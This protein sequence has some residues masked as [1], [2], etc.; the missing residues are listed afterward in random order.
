M[1]QGWLKGKDKVLNFCSNFV[2]KFAAPLTKGRA[3]ATS[4]AV[5]LAITLAVSFWA[6]SV[7]AATDAAARAA[8]GPVLDRLQS[9]RATYELTLL[10][11]REGSDITGARGQMAFEWADACQGWTVSHKVK[12][13][14]QR[15]TGSAINFGWLLRSWEA[16][17]GLSFKF[18]MKRLSDSAESEEISGTATLDAIG[19]AGVATFTQPAQQTIDLPKGTLFPTWHSLSILRALARGDLPLMRTVFDGTAEEGGLADISAF[20]AADHFQPVELKALQGQ[21]SWGLNLAY[22]SPL[23]QSSEPLQEQKL[24]L[25][26]NGVVETFVFDYGDFAIQARLKELEYLPKMAC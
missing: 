20:P 8:F 23:Q 25:F 1:Q 12:V 10:N 15:A 26:Q 6:P 7:T 18:F 4:G 19:G 5:G 14:L 13:S 9:H 16:K 11:S 22:F 21:P 17:D 2:P 3:A 24:R